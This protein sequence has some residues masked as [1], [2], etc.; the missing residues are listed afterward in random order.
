[1][2][3]TAAPPP[4][5]S[6]I[7][8]EL[9]A[10]CQL[11]CPSCPT[12]TGE[13][14]QA[15]GAGFVRAAIFRK[16]LDD[17]PG[18]REIE[19]SNYGEPFLNPDLAQ[20][21]ADADARGVA[22][23]CD[24]GANLNHAR[25][26]VLEAVVRHRLR[27]LR[28]SIDGAGAETYA[29]YRKGGDFAR[30]LANIRAINRHKR[31]YASRYPELTWQFIAFGHNQHEIEAARAL[32]ASLNMQFF[33]KLSWDEDFSPPVDAAALKRDGNLADA[34]RAE[35]KAR[36][37]ADYMDSLC[38]QLWD[39]PQINWDG[40]MLGC[41]RNFWGSFGGNVLHEGLAA[42]F[43]SDGMRHARAMLQGGAP[44]R[45]D[46]PCTTCSIYLDRR[47]HGRWVRRGIAPND[48]AKP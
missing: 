25:D 41:C 47:A 10:S 4:V 33:V 28:C 27:S 19:I 18:I 45:A 38:H 36:T 9:S 7:K 21:L 23:R 35:H 17:N 29:I 48:T 20:I 15:I 8:L 16:L 32:A 11:R 42:A 26:D 3:A 31:H 5:P 30:V 43:D 46:I 44:P 2:T 14:A 24:N 13:T 1:M 6:A 37:G 12:A 34:S 40:R 22:L 39:S